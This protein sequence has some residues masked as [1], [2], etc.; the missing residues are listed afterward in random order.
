MVYRPS[1]ELIPAMVLLDQPAKCS[2][3]IEYV[4]LSR[5][6]GPEIDTV[7]DRDR[8]DIFGNEPGLVNILF[9]VISDDI[10]VE[11]IPSIVHDLFE[12]VQT[13]LPHFGQSGINRR[14]GKFAI[15][16]TVDFGTPGGS[17]SPGGSICGH[18]ESSMVSRFRRFV[19]IDR[20]CHVNHLSSTIQQDY[21]C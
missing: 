8:P 17:V 11:I 4:F 14:I 18:I 19:R 6:I 10:Q 13:D 9:V 1:C 12:I 16:F 15:G 20:F 2:V 21:L 5:L 7:C 3:F